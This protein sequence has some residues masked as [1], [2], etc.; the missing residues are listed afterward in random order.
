MYELKCDVKWLGI[1]KRTN[2]LRKKGNLIVNPNN[3]KDYPDLYFCTS[4]SIE[5]GFVTHR[6]LIKNPKISATEENIICIQ[7]D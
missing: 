7:I 2:Q 1:D 5:E 3:K 6:K 4:G